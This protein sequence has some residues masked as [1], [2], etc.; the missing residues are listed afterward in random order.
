M[1]KRKL[2]FMVR[3][4]TYTQRPKSESDCYIF[5]SDPHGTGRP[6]ID[7]VQQA[8][9]LYPYAQT[10]F[11]GDYIDGRKESK[12][13]LEFVMQ[14]V[15]S[16]RAVALC[17]NHE[18]LLLNFVN[19]GDQLWYINGAKTTIKSLLGQGM[20]RKVAQI[21]LRSNI[22]TQFI[23]SLPLLYE[24]KE[25]IFVHAGIK[26][27]YRDWD[28]LAY[29]NNSVNDRDEF[30][31]WARESYWWQNKTSNDLIFQH[32]N[33]GKAI[34]T[35]HTPTCFIKGKYDT[36]QKGISEFLY[37]DM[38]EMHCPVKMVKYDDEKPRIFTDNGCHSGMVSHNGNI[39]VIDRHGHI[40]DYF[41]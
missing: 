41:D 7:L 5:A 40:V 4:S 14:Q 10:V 25:V 12:A 31:Q 1:R 19:H 6:W 36:P 24:T 32:N 20:S 39:V 21:E 26:C 23:N 9:R 11:G 22:Y 2:I 15:K 16:N 3:L 18:Q 29:Y 13:T 30:Y 38:K 27:Q 35:G 8:Q 37:D 34:V 28:N 33:T 17:G